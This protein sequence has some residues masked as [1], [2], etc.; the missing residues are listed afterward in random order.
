MW[1]YNV[2]RWSAKVCVKSGGVG[3]TVKGV[4]G[5]VCLGGECREVW[6]L[7]WGCPAG[8]GLATMCGKGL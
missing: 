1:G 2:W 3:G 5:G 8:F 4:W 6:G 7:L